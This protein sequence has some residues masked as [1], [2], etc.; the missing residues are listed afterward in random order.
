MAALDR[1]RHAWAPGCRFRGG[2]DGCRRRRGDSPSRTR[3]PETAATAEKSLLCSIL[4]GDDDG[5][6]LVTL[7]GVPGGS[8]QREAFCHPVTQITTNHHKSQI[9]N[10]KSL[11]IYYRPRRRSPPCN[12][13]ES[14]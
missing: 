6:L 4:D 11:L 14:R 5:S 8:F 9:P 13:R 2:S 12:S 1:A 7:L 3:Q 10:P